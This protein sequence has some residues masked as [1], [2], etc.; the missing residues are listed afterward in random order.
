[1]VANQKWT[2]DEDGV[3]RELAKL[4]V[5]PEEITAVLKSRSVAAIKQRITFL[6][7]KDCYAPEID[8][9]AFKRLMKGVK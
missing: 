8:M 7:L 2:E 9:E 4:H 5:P 3:L 6:K 1:M